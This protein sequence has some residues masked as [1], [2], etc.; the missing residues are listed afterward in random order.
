MPNPHPQTAAPGH[1]HPD[2]APAV[3]AGP[4]GAVTRRTAAAWG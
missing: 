1:C 3:P 2:A 4:A